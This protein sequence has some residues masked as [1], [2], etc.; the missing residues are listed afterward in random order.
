MISTPP[1]IDGMAEIE[2]TPRTSHLAMECVEQVHG[3]MIHGAPLQA[4]CADKLFSAIKR[5]MVSL[6]RFRVLA[7]SSSVSSPRARRSPS[8]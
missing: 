7:V 5:R 2:I 3:W 1:A 6:L 8:V 4:C